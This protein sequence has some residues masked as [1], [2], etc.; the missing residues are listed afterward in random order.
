VPNLPKDVDVIAAAFSSQVGI[1]NEALQIPGGGFVWYEVAGIAPSRERSFEEVKDRVEA[2][3]REA[4]IAKRLDAKA[5]EIVDKLKAGAWFA[6]VAAAN[7]VKL[8]SV[9]GLKR[10]GAGPLPA[11]VV[12]EVFR[13]PK[14]G[15]ATT[16]GAEP[17]QRIVFRVTGITV[18]AFDAQGAAAK[19]LSDTL[20]N[21]YADD[22]IAQY[23]GQLQI[24]FGVKINQT[25]L[26]QAIGRGTT[27]QP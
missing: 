5:T 8:E 12:A 26:N 21:A 16:Q 27:D 25:A 4:E 1:E 18:P 20:N 24:D 15:V 6:E 22:L 17:T 3:W 7:G 9:S 10:R 14:N 2:R 11:A 23:V 13:T 19:R